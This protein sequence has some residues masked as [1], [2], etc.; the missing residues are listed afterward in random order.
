MHIKPVMLFAAPLA[1]AL[2]FLWMRSWGVDYM[3]AVTA[4]VTL[5]TAAWW[6][7]EAIPIPAASLL[8]FT[9][10]PLTGVL[11]HR[12][13]V[14]SLGN[15]V[16]LLLMGGFM[17]AKALEKSGMHR[18]FALALLNLV[19]SNGKRIVFAF[20][21]T[22]ASLSMWISNTA[23]TLILLPIALAVLKHVDN[24]PLSVAVLLGLAHAAS[25]GG[26]ATLIGTPPNIVFA[27]VY[28]EVTGREFS[29]AD[30]MKI[31]LPV[32]A[33]GLPLMALWLTR[34]VTATEALRLPAVG[35]WRAGEVRV[36]LVFGITVALWITRSEPLGGWSGL[37]GTPGVGDD[38]VALL[39][40]LV[41]FLLPSGDGDR[42]LD[43]DTALDIPWGML[44]LFA[45]GLTIAK[46]FTS[47]GLA[48]SLAEQLA[49]LAD[50]PLPLLMLCI[51]LGVTF[52]TE[53]TSNTATT[54]LLMPILAAAA[55]AAGTAPELMMIP[56]AMSA[57]CAF[58]LPVATVPN[59]VIFG[60]GQVTIQ[61]MV[62]G[63]TVLNLIMALVIT[64]VCWLL[65]G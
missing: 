7:T 1:S 57:S 42:L 35:K 48:T 41:L 60:A 36:L 30:W 62:K 63:G 49:V 12:E 61:E 56:A 53:L 3:I 16:I 10:F 11:S 14:A 28:G 45:A 5:L 58:M 64:G 6:V 26:V 46:A 40:V 47:S 21:L 4:A 34:K 43:W 23:T 54:T 15:P 33:L 59:A 55:L 52:L 39:A 65:L 51:C 27:G 2:L 31:G 24:R 22:S 38:T 20:M 44:L 37:L 32:V 9:A 17:L 13:A 25:L 29:F 8:P 50:F 19:G 18:R